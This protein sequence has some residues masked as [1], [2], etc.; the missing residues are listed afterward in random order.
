MNTLY[1]HTLFYIPLITSAFKSYAAAKTID[2]LTHLVASYQ[3][4]LKSPCISSQPIL[5][6]KTTEYNHKFNL[7]EKNNKKKKKTIFFFIPMVLESANFLSRYG[8]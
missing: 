6:T 8:N 1:N 5:I 7:I 2:F 4:H 3:P